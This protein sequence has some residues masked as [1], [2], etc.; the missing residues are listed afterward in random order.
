MGQSLFKKHLKFLIFNKDFYCGVAKRRTNN[1]KFLENIFT[2]KLMQ[3]RKLWDN[4]ITENVLG[5]T[6]SVKCFNA[7]WTDGRIQI[8][9][10]SH[11]EYYFKNK[12]TTNISQP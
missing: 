7:S 4:I 3:E 6:V 12:Y 1:R 5:V 11:I 2:Q 10:K 9:I 8:L